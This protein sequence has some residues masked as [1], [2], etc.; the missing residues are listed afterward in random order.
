M[1]VSDDMSLEFNDLA[2]RFLWTEHHVE[3]V[4]HILQGPGFERQSG[5]LPKPGSPFNSFFIGFKALI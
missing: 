5:N 1:V 3:E 2:A 4:V